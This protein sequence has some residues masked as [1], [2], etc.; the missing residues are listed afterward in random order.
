MLTQDQHRFDESEETEDEQERRTETCK[1][2]RVSW[3]RISR[4]IL[5]VLFPEGG[6]VKAGVNAAHAE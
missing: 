2:A 5:P 1:E 6:T 4:L 3:L